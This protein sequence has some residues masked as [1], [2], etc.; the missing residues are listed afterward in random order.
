MVSSPATFTVELRL[1]Q[2]KHAASIQ[3]A[4]PTEG[5]E[6][7][8]IAFDTLSFGRARF[9]IKVDQYTLLTVRLAD[10]TTGLDPVQV[11]PVADPT[12]KSAADAS[13]AF[14]K[15]KMRDPSFPDPHGFGVFSN[16]ADVTVNTEQ[17]AYGHNVTSENVGLM[18]LAAAAR[19]DRDTF[20]GTARYVR[21][22]MRSPF[23]GVV[24]WAVDKTTRQPMVQVDDPLDPSINGNAPLDDFRVIRG[25]LL[26]HR[27][28]GDAWYLDLARELGIGLRWT[29]VTDTDNEVSAAFP[30]YPDGLA[31]YA[32]NWIETAAPHTGAGYLDHEPLP[33][34][35]CDLA[36]IDA[37]VPIDTWWDGVA[38]SCARMMLA[39]E[40][41][42]PAAPSGIF[43]G[44]YYAS[45]KSFSGDFE[46]PDAAQGRLVKAIQTLWTALHLARYGMSGTAGAPDAATRS[47]ALAAAK[48]GLSFF[49]EFY[50][51]N[52]RVP[53]YL[54]FEGGD[55]AN[56]LVDPLAD[57][58]LSYTQ[59][60]VVNDG[61]EESEYE[62]EPRIYALLAR[63][64]YE[65]GDATLARKVVVERILPF[66]DVTPT[67]ASFGNIGGDL[68]G[69]RLAEAWNNL[70]PILAIHE[71]SGSGPL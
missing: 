48:R 63:L 34:D 26:G 64:A 27:V 37:L 58:C 30:D 51:A 46:M 68:A 67:S 20:D 24:N 9:T 14:V 13:W 12:L 28:F 45:S 32:F 53:E 4:S 59:P 41:G 1:P 60:G 2:G 23:L 29:S 43:H 52:G 55:A 10:G 71:I 47:S 56:C 11:V 18:L 50:G 19:G 25:L 15:S 44:S 21:D 36:A 62:G 39:A 40:V 38:A 16:Q 57:P 49:A 69:D 22:V 6:V 35:Y 3:A 17:Y 7:G 61:D 70:E 8:A 42:A 5:A 33:I 65:L 31:A 54:T 66:Q